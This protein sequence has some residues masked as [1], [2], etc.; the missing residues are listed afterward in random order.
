MIEPDGGMPGKTTDERWI[1]TA[2]ALLA[3]LNEGH[4]SQTGA[5]RIHVRRLIDFLKLATPQDA[6][7]VRHLFL[8]MVKAGSPPLFKDGLQSIFAAS[9]SGGLHD[10]STLR[11]IWEQVASSLPGQQ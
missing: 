10:S 9:A 2:L 7:P 4:S 8:R 3:L 11:Q 1:A 5:F 6:A